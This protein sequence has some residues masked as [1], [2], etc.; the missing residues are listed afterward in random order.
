MQQYTLENAAGMRCKI[1][2]HGGI[3]TEWSCINPENTRTDIV[4]GFDCLDD[5]LAGHPY[6]GATTGRV[7]GRISGA[8]FILDNREINLAVNDPPNHLHGGDVGLDKRLWKVERACASSLELSY[9]SPDGEEGYPGNVQFHTTYS[10]SEKGALS[11]EYRATTDQATPINLTHHSYFNLAGA[12]E[13]DIL[14]HQLQIEASSYSVTDPGGTL[15]EKRSI[16]PGNGCSFLQSRTIR[17]ALNEI[18][19][20]HGDNYFVDRQSNKELIRVARLQELVSGRSMEVW[21]TEDCLQLYLGKH[22]PD[23]LIGKQ[24][25]SYHPF[26]ALCLECQGYP[27]AVNNPRHG[28]S[29]LQP[30]DE[31]YHQTIYQLSTQASQKNLN[32]INL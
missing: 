14:D 15:L 13:G 22:L 32:A 4:L 29:I 19:H 1:I 31:Y 16:D 20:Q 17:E 2:T 3:L 21:S 30:E 27:D 28:E 5:Y 24:G 6:F 23:G 26:S 11:I 8:R 18:A 25:K 10:L 12:G 7:A 9:F